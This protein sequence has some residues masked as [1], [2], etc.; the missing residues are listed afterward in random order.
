MESSSAHTKQRK[1]CQ[2]TGRAGGSPGTSH[3]PNQRA[4]SLGGTRGSLIPGYQV[5]LWCS[6]AHGQS[7]Q[8]YGE[9]ES[10]L[11]QA[12]LGQGLMALGG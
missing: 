7:G 4:A 2:G 12:S 3:H 5:P 9:L 6:R 8:S 10:A 1:K 11:L